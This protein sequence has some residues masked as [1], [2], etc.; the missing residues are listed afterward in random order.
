MD[1]AQLT[2]DLEALRD[3]ASGAAADAPDTAALDQLEVEILGKKGE[4][5]AILRGI[6]SLPAE[7]HP[8]VDAIANQVRVAVEGALAEARTRLGGAELAAR[9]QAEAVDVTTP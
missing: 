2:A 5:T 1:L 7:D 9:M 3:R 8:K 4:L 6:G